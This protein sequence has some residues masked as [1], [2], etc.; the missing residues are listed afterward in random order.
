MNN[1]GSSVFE[2]IGSI[3]GAVLV[4]FLIAIFIN[5]A[6]EKEEESTLEER[7][8]AAN[9]A[10][11]ASQNENSSN[12]MY[13]S[14]SLEDDTNNTDNLYTIASDTANMSKRQICKDSNF[15]V[16]LLD[17][18][19]LGYV[20]SALDYY[21]EEIES[22]EEVLYAIYEIY[23]YD[24]EVH[25]FD[26]YYSF[27]AYVDSVLA[28][29]EGS[30]F[31]VGID[32]YCQY[33]KYELDPGKTSIVIEAYKVNKG[34]DEIKLFF[35]DNAWVLHSEDVNKDS[36]IYDSV[37][38]VPLSSET[39]SQG[40]IISSG[41]CEVIFDDFEIVNPENTYYN[42]NDYAVFKFTVTNNDSESIDYSLIGYNMRGY[43]NQRLL[44]GADYIFDDNLNGYINIFNVDEIKPGMTVKLYVAYE[45]TGN[46]ANQYECVYDTGYIYND[47]LGNV[48]VNI[49]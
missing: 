19:S 14:Q 36:F 21:T 16:A 24:D 37:F 8:Q 30:N 47:V 23:N 49:E 43:A 38:S 28:G 3:I 5:N 2:I 45:L 18:R 26:D 44:D 1:R 39:S 31:L 48:V 41:S 15:Y 42:E 46:K 33:Q 4:L 12:Q 29:D 13:A 6:E 22:D 10:Y 17:V 9:E 27:S 25:S 40:E 7:F 20:Q 32:G 35:R 11:Y 34:W